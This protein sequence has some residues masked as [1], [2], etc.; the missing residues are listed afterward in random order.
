VEELVAKEKE[1]QERLIA[2]H[3]TIVDCYEKKIGGRELENRVALQQ[4]K[5]VVLKQEV[6]DLLDYIE[7]I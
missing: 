7:E 2:K 4:Q 3:S 6:E 5:V 1:L